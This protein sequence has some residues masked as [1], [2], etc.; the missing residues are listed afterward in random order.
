MSQNRDGCEGSFLVLTRHF[1]HDL[2][3]IKLIFLCKIVLGH[4]WNPNLSSKLEA[5]GFELRAAVL[6]HLTAGDNEGHYSNN[7]KFLL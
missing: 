3:V 6:H 7:G 4:F 5:G 2:G 1:K